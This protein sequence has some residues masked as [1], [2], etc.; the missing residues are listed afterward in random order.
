MK[1]ILVV[2]ILLFVMAGCNNSILNGPS[3]TYQEVTGSERE[4]RDLKAVEAADDSQTAEFSPE[5]TEEELAFAKAIRP[6]HFELKTLIIRMSGTGALFL[7]GEADIR[8][9]ENIITEAKRELPAIRAKLLK[10]DPPQT[11][12]ATLKTYLDALDLYQDAI[13]E[14]EHYFATKDVSSLDRFIEMTNSAN[15][16]IKKVIY[17]MWTD[18]LNAK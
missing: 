16:S 6:I 3:Q 18:E 9:V 11:M 5:L 13:A 1:K 14:F 15:D 8:S 7:S 2:M 4:E 10:I 12:E 17:R